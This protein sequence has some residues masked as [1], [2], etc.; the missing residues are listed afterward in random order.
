VGFYIACPNC[1]RRSY[2]EY[3]FG[4]ELRPHDPDADIAQDYSS[5]WLRDNEQWS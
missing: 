4:G 1:G 5:V 2:E 3:W